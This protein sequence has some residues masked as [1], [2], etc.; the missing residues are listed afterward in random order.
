MF[1][2]QNARFIDEDN[3]KGQEIHPTFAISIVFEPVHK[4]KKCT[5][6]YASIFN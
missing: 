1:R 5:Y 3:H 2:K 6:N 4:L